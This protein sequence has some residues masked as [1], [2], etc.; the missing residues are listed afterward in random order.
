MR[1]HENEIDDY[2]DFMDGIIFPDSV[3]DK[4]IT[5]YGEKSSKVN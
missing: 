3:S 2:K 1:R 5:H 4:S